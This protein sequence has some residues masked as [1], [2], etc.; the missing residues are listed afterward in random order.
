MTNPYTLLDAIVDTLQAIP[1]LVT[2]CG[3]DSNNIVGYKHQWPDANS[4]ALALRQLKAGPS[5]MVLYR[6]TGPGRWGG[7]PSRQ[8]NYA[9]LIRDGLN[10]DVAAIWTAIIDGVPTTGSGL[11]WMYEIHAAVDLIQE[12]SFELRSMQVTDTAFMDYWEAQF[13]LTEKFA[14]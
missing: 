7:V 14:G 12:P 9:L 5:I 2:L 11:K 4:W 10:V 1:A 3:S 6:G 8:H 13:A